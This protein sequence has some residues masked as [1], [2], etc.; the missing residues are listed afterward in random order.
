MH[1]FSLKLIQCFAVGLGKQ[2]DYFDKWFKDECSSTFRA[3]HYKSREEEMFSDGKQEFQLVTPEHADSGF[4]TLLSTFMFP[5]LEVLIDGEYKPI[6]PAKDAIIVN[7]G[8][9]L[10]KITNY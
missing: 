6:K 3:I 4:I 10:E 8:N 9:M 5:G 1:S 7:I 2:A